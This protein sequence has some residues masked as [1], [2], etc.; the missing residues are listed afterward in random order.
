VQ[1]ARI[2]QLKQGQ[3]I[4]TRVIDRRHTACSVDVL[5]GT[6]GEADLH[7]L[8][9]SSGFYICRVAFH[10]TQTRER[11][12]TYYIDRDSTLRNLDLANGQMARGR[13]RGIRKTGL[14]LKRAF[15]RRPGVAERGGGDGCYKAAWSS[16]THQTCNTLLTVRL[17]R[18]W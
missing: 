8:G 13:G 14:Q 2:L 9:A 5:L 15:T 7:V 1:E 11:R 10:L 6:D 12:E 16:A 3:N 18:E 17:Q 4:E